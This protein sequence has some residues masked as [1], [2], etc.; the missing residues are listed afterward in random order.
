MLED[1]ENDY[2]VTRDLLSQIKGKSFELVWIT[3]HDTASEAMRRNDYDIYLFKYQFFQQNGL[4][5]LNEVALN[6]D[7]APIILL[8]ESELAVEAMKAG[9]MDYLVKDQIDPPLLERSIRYVIDRTQTLK[10]LR[11]SQLRLESV[12]SSLKDVVWSV[13]ATTFETLYISPAAETIYGRSVSEFFENPRLW[14]EVVHPDDRE[15]VWSLSQVLLQ[16]GSKDLEYRIIRPDGEVRWI[17]DRG[18]LAH[19]ASCGGLRIDGIATDITSRKLAEEEK[20]KFISLV[21]NSSDFIAMSSIEGKLLFVNE[22]GFKLVGLDNLEEALSKNIAEYFPADAFQQFCEMTMPK[23]MTIGRSEGEGQLRHFKTGKSIDVQRSCFAIRHPQTDEF[24]CFATVQ[25][26]ITE[27]NQAQ[28]QLQLLESAVKH[29]TES[30]VITTANLDLPGPEITF[31]NPAF[32]KITG[33]TATDAIGKTPRILQGPKTDRASLNQLRQCLS[34]GKLFSGETINYRK[35]GTEFYLEWHVAPISNARGEITHFV[36]VQR[37][38]TE[39]KHVTEQLLHHA[40]NDALTSLPNRRLFMER[41]S[42]AAKIGRQRKNSMFAVLFIDLDGFKVINDSLGH[43]IGDQLLVTI[44]RRLETCLRY[45]DTLARLGGDEFALLLEDIKDANDAIDLAE[46]IQEKLK[47]PFN[48]SGQKVFATATI[49]IA[50]SSTDYDRPEDLL[51]NADTAMYR[52]K[53]LGKARHAVFDPSMYTCAVARLQ[54]DIALRWA[55][56]RQELRLHYQPIMSLFNSKI[57]GFEALV[58]WQHPERGLVMP[59]EFI[60]V[61]EETGLIIPIGQWVLQEACCQMRLWEQQFSP[62]SLLTVS[63]NLSAKQ[64]SQPDLIE[65]VKQ[66]LQKTGLDA[67]RL[68]LEI[69]ESVVMDNAEAATMMLKQLQALGV[70]LSIDDFGTGYSSLSYLH[71]FPTN[72]LK[73]DRSFVSRTNSE[74]EKWE[75]VWTIITLAHNLGMTVIAEGIETAEQLDKLRMLK[76]E[77]GQGYFFSKPLEAKSVGAWI[78][79]VQQ[80][81]LNGRT[82]FLSASNV[83]N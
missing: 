68:K 40:F 21:E 73:I 83:D 7:K 15:R 35:D 28:K 23:L 80:I 22:A 36:A 26:D 64:F 55:I 77:Y 78:K 74:Q 45:R 37:D 16:V 29:A 76:C 54:L 65:Q 51:R 25:R 39:R 72:T 32:T 66:I 60:S 69:T 30:I 79:N 2:I 70:Q 6:S 82:N 48:L 31:V 24:M 44:C 18:R 59:N 34:Q 71:R 47:L 52:A 62:D 10:A 38:I 27:R 41:L 5:L 50:L 61:A 46:R 11:E 13:R 33:Y 8:G 42:Q 14:F 67:H 53:L 43:A 81:N 56:K 58:R 20:Q 17:H 3:N 12:L 49:G 19:N 1:N 4:K 57:I 63:V 75:I 9:A